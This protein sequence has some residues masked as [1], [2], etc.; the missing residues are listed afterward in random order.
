[1]SCNVSEEQLWSWIDRN[2]PELEEHLAKCPSCRARAQEL[3]A[4]IE[5]VAVG[6]A[7]TSVPLP[8]RIGSYAVKR[9]LGDDTH[10][11]RR[12]A[13]LRRGRATEDSR[14]RLPSPCQPGSPMRMKAAQ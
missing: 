12:G 13:L 1:M 11:R 3:R 8:E 6:S 10:T 4:R 9:L 5:T 2:A 14:E 7:P